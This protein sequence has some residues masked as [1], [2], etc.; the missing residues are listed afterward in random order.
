ME[1]LE[2]QWSNIYTVHY[3]GELIL[4]NAL[5]YFGFTQH[6]NTMYNP[7]HGLEKQPFIYGV[8]IM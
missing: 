3:N 4:F 7:Y 5:V 1:T 8:L 2:V 6:G